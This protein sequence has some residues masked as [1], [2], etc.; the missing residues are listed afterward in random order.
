MAG[1]F[2]N[3]WTLLKNR[4]FEV[5]PRYEDERLQRLEQGH[6]KKDEL[7]DKL[8]DI[9]SKLQASD[10]GSD[11]LSA[12]RDNLENELYQL[13]RNPEGARYGNPPMN[14]IEPHTGP[15]FQEQQ[16]QEAEE[17]EAEGI[18]LPDGLRVSA[19]PP[20]SV[21]RAGSIMGEGRPNLKE[22]YFGSNNQTPAAK[23][24][25]ITADDFMRPSVQKS[26][27][28]AWALLK[29][30]PAMHDGM[31]SVHPAAMNYGYA[32]RMAE[33]LDEQKNRG[34]YPSS[35]VDEGKSH[36]RPRLDVDE[37]AADVVQQSPYLRE[38]GKKQT[39]FDM[40]R[41][42]GPD[43]MEFNIRRTPRNSIE[44]PNKPGEEMMHTGE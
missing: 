23:N 3:A 7:K 17:I 2:N 11:E 16:R 34:R 13:M 35:Y 38:Q 19:V 1:A 5:D 6:D 29:A 10:Y 28:D 39:S 14:M 26:F 33:M 24:E 18:E 43:G 12:E 4:G 8:R 30:N 20:A 25:F 15:M 27:D 40:S 44:H 21:G 32:A 31:Y 36:L 22:L 42:Y 37:R 41:A 9:H